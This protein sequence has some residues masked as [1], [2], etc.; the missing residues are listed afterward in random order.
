MVHHGTLL[1]TMDWSYDLLSEEEKVLFGR[2][3][4]FAG[5][6]TLEAE[7]EVCGGGSIGEGEVLDLL[8]SLVDKSLVAFEER[9]GEARYGMLETVRQYASGKLEES[10]E[11]SE[12]R[13]KHAA[14]FLGLAERAWPHLK[15]RGQLEWLGRLETEHE[16]LR[17]AMRFLLDEDKTQE[18]VRL[19]WA[20]WLFW[21]LH[22]HQAEGY[23]Y[24]GELLG[25]K[26]ALRPSRGPGC[27]SSG[28]TCLTGG[29][30]SKGRGGCSKRPPPCP[31]KRGT[32]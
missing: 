6:F 8:T 26:E 11:A 18:A 4:V 17:S 16:N 19:A 22:G 10:G 15:G 14:W 27:S 30:V 3:S 24:A 28:E 13:G 20:L 29:R 31:G 23:R 2:L 7:E 9:D 5:G 1:A 32:T 21:Y 25:K 12:A